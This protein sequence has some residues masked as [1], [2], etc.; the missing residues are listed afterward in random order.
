[1]SFEA[2]HAEIMLAR[3]YLVP[4]DR[5]EQGVRIGYSYWL[6]LPSGKKLR[7]IRLTQQSGGSY[8]L[9]RAASERTTGKR[10]RQRFS[11]S[12]NE[13]LGIIDEEVDTIRRYER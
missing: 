2:I 13:L 11:G 4:E 9:V 3:P 6:R 12:L 8:E 7:A 5:T 1:M 10:L